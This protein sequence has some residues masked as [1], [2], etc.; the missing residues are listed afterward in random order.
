MIAAVLDLGIDLNVW[1]WVWLIIGV[2]FAVIELTILAGSFVLLPFAISAFAAA[3]LG[4]YDVPIEV[5]WGVFV[6]GGAILWIALY[7]RVMKFAGDNETAPGVGA[8]RLVGLTAIVIADIDPD[9]T[10]RRGRVKVE[11]ETWSALTHVEHTIP[12]G[13]KVHIDEMVGTRV[14]VSPVTV[15]PP[16]SPPLGPP[17]SQPQTPEAP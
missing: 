10:D 12:A 6:F 2:F 3:L 17:Q 14:I 8:N 4:F 11:S 15:P 9:D 13:S 7:K 5:Q 1:P 16:T